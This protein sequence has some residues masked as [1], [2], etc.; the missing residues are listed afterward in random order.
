ML[1]PV[2]AEICME[3]HLKRTQALHNEII[4]FADGL[5]NSYSL[6]IWEKIEIALTPKCTILY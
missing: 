1:E 6:K 3:K 5:R 2:S 4:R